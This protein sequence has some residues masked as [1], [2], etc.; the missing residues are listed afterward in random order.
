MTDEKR[1]NAVVMEGVGGEVLNRWMN[2]L[3]CKNRG[4]HTGKKEAKIG[5]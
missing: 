5:L 3:K 1:D 4:G 2:R